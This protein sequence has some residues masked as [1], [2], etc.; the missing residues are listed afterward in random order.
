LEQYTL[1]QITPPLAAKIPKSKSQISNKS[2]KD[3]NL[4]NQQ[5]SFWILDI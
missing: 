4:K 5:R 2:Q 3:Q 1:G